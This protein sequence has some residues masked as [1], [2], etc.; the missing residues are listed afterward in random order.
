MSPRAGTLSLLAL[1]L[2]ACRRAP[3]PS[4]RLGGVEVDGRTLE[5]GRLAYEQHCAQCHGERGDGRGPSALGLEP[6][7][8]DFRAGVLEYASVPSGELPTDEDLLRAPRHGLA[9]TAMT[10][11]PLDESTLRAIAQHLKTLS[12][13]W[14]AGRAG[15]PVAL[16]EDPWRGRDA[17]ALA[18]GE[19]VYHAVALCWSCHPAY[20]PRARLGALLR[21]EQGAEA[22]G[23]RED[24]AGP[25]PQPCELG[26]TRLPTD[27]LR[28]PL[29]AGGTVRDVARTLAAG[30]GGTT[31]PGYRDALDDAALWSLA[32]Y[33]RWLAERRDTPEG[34]ALLEAVR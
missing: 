18:R 32:R 13:R 34:Y 31:M 8:R 19:R 28:H 20:V 2:L 11:Q 14:R 7:P 12:P 1:A 9:G 21:E 22:E 6:A 10:E 4:Q 27:F 3:P 25:V 24:L 29:R 33:V 5:R 15:A 17:E 16:G 23:V 30:L 26:G